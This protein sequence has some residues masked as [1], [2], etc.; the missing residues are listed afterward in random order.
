[1][2]QKA[3][4][5][6]FLNELDSTVPGHSASREDEGKRGPIPSFDV[7]IEV[8]LMHQSE[9]PRTK[10][11][12]IRNGRRSAEGRYARPLGV[13][14]RAVRVRR[15]TKSQDSVAGSGQTRRSGDPPGRSRTKAPGDRNPK[16]CGLSSRSGRTS[17]SRLLL[18]RV[19]GDGPRADA[20]HRGVSARRAEEWSGRSIDSGN[21]R[22]PQ[23]L[24]ESTGTSTSRRRSPLRFL[25]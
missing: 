11:Q 16:P 23:S 15:L 17:R 14:N 10:D 4:P 18:N 2:P 25:R 13:D 1:M 7:M 20:A 9:A 12:I 22:D 3:S 6:R 24:Q 5:E 21:R 19:P 8:N